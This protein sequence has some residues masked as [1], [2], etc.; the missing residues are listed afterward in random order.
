MKVWLCS[1]LKPL[2]VYMYMST[3]IFIQYL[4]YSVVAL[5]PRSAQL[6]WNPVSANHTPGRLFYYWQNDCQLITLQYLFFLPGSVA[7]TG[8]PETITESISSVWNVETFLHPATGPGTSDEGSSRRRDGLTACDHHTSSSESSSAPLSSRMPYTGSG[9]VLFNQTSSEIY[10]AS[11]RNVVLFFLSI[12]FQIHHRWEFPPS[13]EI[14][15]EGSR[16]WPGSESRQTSTVRMWAN[17]W[18]Q[19]IA[20]HERE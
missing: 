12:H 7:Q 8:L 10:L 2:Y 16:G 5:G 13:V 9:A 14:P 15:S 17:A 11:P 4:F 3:L 18:E 1:V 6:L 20:W 19:V